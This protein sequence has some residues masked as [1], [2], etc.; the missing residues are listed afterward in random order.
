[1]SFLPLRKSP[2]HDI[3]NTQQI[4]HVLSLGENTEVENERNVYLRKQ[5]FLFS[6]FGIN[7]DTLTLETKG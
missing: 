2:G 4:S 7:T 1:M 6:F 5:S 3:N